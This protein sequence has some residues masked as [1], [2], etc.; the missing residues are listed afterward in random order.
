MSSFNKIILIGRLTRDPDIKFIPSGKSV[1][2]FG[3]AVN[4]TR[5]KEKMAD[6]FE[7]IVWEKL[8][9]ICGKYL[10]KGSLVLIEGEVQ[11]GSYENKD[12]GKVKTFEVVCNNMRM[13]G[14]ERG[15]SDAGGN[16]YEKPKKSNNSFKNE[17]IDEFDADEVPF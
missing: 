17:V 9:D 5:S 7:I 12:G 3:L 11:T 13:L 8:A 2:K 10:N 16:N 1:G 14:G 15:N 4:R 6:F